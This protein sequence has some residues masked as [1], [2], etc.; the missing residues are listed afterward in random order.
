MPAPLHGPHVHAKKLCRIVL[1]QGLV[2]EQAHHFPLRLRK[3]LHPFVEQGPVAEILR[4]DRLAMEASAG[5][6]GRL[7]VGVVVAT[8]SFRSEMVPGEVDQFPPDVEGCQVEKVPGRLHLH[9]REGVVSADGGGIGFGS[10]A[11]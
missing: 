2:E 4:L 9:L 6:I 5:F 11:S 3:L 1:A 7:V 10:I 8:D